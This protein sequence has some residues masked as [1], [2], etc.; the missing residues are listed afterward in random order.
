MFGH[1]FCNARFELV[2]AT[3]DREIIERSRLVVT[4][5]QTADRPGEF[6]F[7]LGAGPPVDRLNL[8]LP[9]LNTVT[10]ADFL[11]R[12]DTKSPWHPVAQGVF[13]RLQSTDGELRN[14]P[15]ASKISPVRFWLVRVRQP[16]SALGTG[17]LRLEAGWRALEV[18]FL[19]RGTR[20]FTLAYGSGSVTGAVTPLAALPGTVTPVRVTLS[21]SKL[22]GGETR[23]K[24]SSAAFPWKTSI[25]WAT[26]AASAA[27]LGGMAYRLT[28]ELNKSD[29]H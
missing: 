22:L 28:R 17:L 23:L 4:A 21:A 15:V 12:S 9:E 19:A 27:L 11:S 24:A 1:A 14:G 26:L 29:T 10:E 2:S 8:E 18:V 6:Q 20:P 25:L 7:D 16:S 13:Y 3:A 5:T